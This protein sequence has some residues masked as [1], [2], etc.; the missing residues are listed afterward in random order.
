[1]SDAEIGYISGA[2]YAYGAQTTPEVTENTVKNL[3]NVEIGR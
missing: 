1:M 2:G 3:P